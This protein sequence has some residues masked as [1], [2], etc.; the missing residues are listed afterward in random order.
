MH[1]A[2]MF[3]DLRLYFSIHNE[4]QRK[5]Y[6]K[7]FGWRF[8]AKDVI[9]QCKILHN[10]QSTT[11][12]AVFF[13]KTADNIFEF[14]TE[15]YIAGAFFEFCQIFRTAIRENTCFGCFLLCIAR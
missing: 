15:G 8:S 13:S 3:L 6:S 5:L 10:S 1:F 14:A 7:V 12:E 11:Y 9:L 2:L 4:R